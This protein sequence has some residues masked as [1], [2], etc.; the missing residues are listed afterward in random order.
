VLVMVYSE[1]NHWGFTT[2]RIVKKGDRFKTLMSFKG[3]GET[4]LKCQNL[5]L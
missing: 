1:V 2:D 3:P 5:V 4:K